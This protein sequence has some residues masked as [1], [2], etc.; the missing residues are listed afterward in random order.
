MAP[1]YV[2]KNECPLTSKSL[3]ACLRACIIVCFLACMQMHHSE[4]AYDNYLSLPLLR[5]CWIDSGW[6]RQTET[7]EIMYSTTNKI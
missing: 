7:V 3:L 5:K 6:T 2:P 1:T 4:F